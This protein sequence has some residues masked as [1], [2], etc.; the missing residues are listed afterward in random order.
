[1]YGQAQGVPLSAIREYVRVN[2]DTT[3]HKLMILLGFICQWMEL[4]M[5]MLGDLGQVE[6]G[7]ED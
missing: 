7:K 5:R 6:P 3:S 4:R 2:E 1:M